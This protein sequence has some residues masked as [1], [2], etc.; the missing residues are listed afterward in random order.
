MK[1]K[2]ERIPAVLMRGG[3]SRGVFFAAEDLPVD[4]DRKLSVILA[5]LGSPDRYGR[6]IDGLGGATSSTSK[7]VIVAPG[8]DATIDVEYTFGQVSIF[9][10]EVDFG[11]NCGNL[12]A[13]VGPYAIEQGLVEA[14]DPVTELRMLNTNTGKTIVARVPSP[15]GVFDPEGPYSIPGVPRPGAKIELDFMDPGGGRT[16]RLMPSGNA[17]DGLR[18]DG[19]SVAVSIV[20]AGNLF[21]FGLFSD[22]GLVGDESADRIDSDDAIL[23]TAEKVRAAGGV[24]AGLDADPNEVTRASPS[25]PK[26]V[27]IGSPRAYRTT[28]GEEV[29]AADVDLTV[30]AISMGKVHRSYPATATICTGV[31]AA[32]EGTLVQRIVGGATRGRPI[33]IGHAAGVTEVEAILAEASGRTRAERV[34]VSRTARRLM[35]GAVCIPMGLLRD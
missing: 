23:A 5:A 9:T 11:G 33:R 15:G 1:L 32:L 8:R 31:A 16:G 20:D 6:Q 7:V 14:T 28:S 25:S 34:T 30:K 26:I 29:A 18:V 35:E 13:A 27:L 4:A 2:Q 21:V 19:L 10:P 24:A 12:T 3:T 17:Q 22:F